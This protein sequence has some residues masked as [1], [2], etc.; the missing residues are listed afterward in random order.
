MSAV[1]NIPSAFLDASPVSL[2]QSRPSP[3]RPLLSVRSSLR[4]LHF[5]TNTAPRIGSRGVVTSHPC[6]RRGDR[7]R[8]GRGGQDR[9]ARRHERQTDTRRD[10]A[11]T[12]VARGDRIS[13]RGRRARR[14]ESSRGAGGDRGGGH[15]LRGSVPR[16]LHRWCGKSECAA[17]H[18]IE[19]AAA[20][21]RRAQSTTDLATDAHHHPVGRGE[22][23]IRRRSPR[24]TAEGNHTTGHRGTE[25]TT[26]CCAVD[27][28]IF[29]EHTK[30]SQVVMDRCATHRGM[31]VQR[32]R[33]SCHSAR[34][35]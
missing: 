15:V 31:A 21:T 18:A 33:R 34:C 32:R 7:R 20:H 22:S 24:C 11:Q 29:S 5:A 9:G 6:T 8:G 16:A 19:S 13:S 14:A 23:A 17:I 1:L 27:R 26:G 25:H 2:A 30:W 12:S 10:A 35:R 4:R 3:V 28:G